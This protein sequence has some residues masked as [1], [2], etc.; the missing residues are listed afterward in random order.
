M[1]TLT[2]H[3]E[4]GQLVWPGALSQPLGQPPLLGGAA[5]SA[6]GQLRVLGRLGVLAPPLASPALS[7]GVA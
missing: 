1:G 6:H 5:S 4:A 7:R 3:A 2:G